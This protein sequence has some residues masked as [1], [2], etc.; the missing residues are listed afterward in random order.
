MGHLLKR[1]RYHDGLLRSDHS[2]EFM[3]PAL[4]IAAATMALG[5][6]RRLRID[7]R[8]DLREYRAL[9]E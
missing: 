9:S 3:K 8:F 6:I 1:N 7:D 5:L 4:R 2:G